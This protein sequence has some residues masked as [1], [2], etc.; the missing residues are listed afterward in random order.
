M[1]LAKSTDEVSE[2]SHENGHTKHPGCGLDRRG[3]DA[4]F[5]SRHRSGSPSALRRSDLVPPLPELSPKVG[6]G[7]IRRRFEVA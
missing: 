6:D 2:S 3:W 5:H 4:N 7:V 1:S